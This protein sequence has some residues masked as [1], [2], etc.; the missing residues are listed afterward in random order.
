MNANYW[1]QEPN[2]VK[3]TMTITMT[4]EE[5]RTLQQQLPQAWPSWRFANE[6]SDMISH[7]NKHF[8]AS[9]SDNGSPSRE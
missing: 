8:S 6:I 1:I 2:K 7:A 9:P 5:W 4:I 3:T